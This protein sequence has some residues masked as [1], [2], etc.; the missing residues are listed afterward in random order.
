MFFL[1]VCH[2]GTAASP[3]IT[4]RV[5]GNSAGDQV[6]I[7]AQRRSQQ[8]PPHFQG[9]NLR[10][11]FHLLKLQ[12][13]QSRRPAFPAVAAMGSGDQQVPSLKTASTHS[14]GK[15]LEAKLSS[16][17]FSVLVHPS[18]NSLTHHSAKCIFLLGDGA[19]L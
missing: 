16:E 17:G 2:M 1:H 4:P 6:C 18:L 12:M 11:R 10:H 5:L 19:V 7:S 15:G 13:V 9:D 3:E 14:T 8:L